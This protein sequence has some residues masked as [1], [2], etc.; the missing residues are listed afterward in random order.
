MNALI[1]DAKPS[2]RSRPTRARAARLLVAG[3]LLAAG[4]ATTVLGFRW[5]LDANDVANAYRSAPVCGSAEHT[6]GTDCARRE[7]G[8]VT[9]RHTVEGDGTT[10]YVTVARETAPGHRY[11]VDRD[12]YRAA[13]VGTDV[14]VTTFRGRVVEVASGGHRSPNPGT[15]W[16]SSLKVALLAGL[17]AALTITA[18][19]WVQEGSVVLSF[20]TVMGGFTAGTAMLGCLVIMTAQLPVAALLAIP[21][22]GWLFMTACGVMVIRD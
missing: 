7:T 19:T 15:P 2:A 5:F 18:L 3:L 20:A 4:L 22:L 8:K 10:Y 16:L 17:G 21:A 9:N 13:K 12:F 11:E 1:M 14:A 6:P